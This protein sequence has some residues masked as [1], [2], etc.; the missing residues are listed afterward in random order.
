MPSVGGRERSSRWR[1]ACLAALFAFVG[2]GDRGPVSRPDVVIVSIDTLRADHVSIYGYD[3][4]TTPVIDAFSR[5]GARFARAYTPMPTT[6]PAHVAMFT[7]VHPT[8]LGVTRNGLVVPDAA[9]TLAES[10]AEQGYRTAAFVSAPPLSASTGISQGFAE[11][12]EERMVR[13]GADTAALAASWLVRNRGGGPVFLFVHLFDPHT[14]YHAPR[15]LRERFG[16]PERP[17]PPSFEF[18]PEDERLDASR[19]RQ[20]IAAY[21]AEIADADEAFGGILAAVERTGG[22]DQT[23]VMLVSDHGET[24]DELYHSHRYAFDHGEF[25]YAHQLHVPWILAGA[26]IPEGEVFDAP[27]STIDLTP[28]VLDLVGAPG[29]RGVHGA[30]LL[31][32]LRGESPSTAV[33]STRRSFKRVK[34]PYLRGRL[35][36]LVDGPWQIIQGDEGESEVFELLSSGATKRSVEPGA[37][38]ARLRDLAPSVDQRP[39]D[40]P[41]VLDVAPDLQERLRALGYVE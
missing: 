15:D 32:V 12:D 5:R 40:G 14:P 4:P 8:S 2:C 28:T 38:Q 16:A 36:S 25:L 31:P 13:D 29:L 20:I 18:L 41:A 3:R 26:G 30:S 22:M 6:L 21:D 19:I 34:R 23:V 11:F 37:M 33:L 27:V 39:L 1:R 7:G 9:K 35:Y 24:L 10:L 17:E